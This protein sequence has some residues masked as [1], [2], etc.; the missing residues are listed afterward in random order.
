M[1]KPKNGAVIGQVVHAHIEPGEFATHRRV[2][3]RFFH[4]WVKEVE[5]ELVLATVDAQHGGDC[6]WRAATC[7][8]GQSRRPL[9]PK[10]PVGSFRQVT[11]ACA[12][13]CVRIYSR[14]GLCALCLQCLTSGRSCRG[15]ADHS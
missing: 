5:V 14:A 11:R 15:F 12:W 4:H 3:Q 6:E 7:G 8:T 1:L 2:I 13:S 9:R 10:G